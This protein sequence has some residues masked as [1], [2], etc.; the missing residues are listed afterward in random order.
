MKNT[1]STTHNYKVLKQT[2]SVFKNILLDGVKTLKAEKVTSTFEVKYE[3]HPKTNQPFKVVNK[4][5]LDEVI[6][7]MSFDLV[8]VTSDQLATYRK[9][10]IS[11]FVLL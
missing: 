6:E 2:T 9:K 8:E 5:Q 7:P 4:N 10:G 3:L 11:S 1:I